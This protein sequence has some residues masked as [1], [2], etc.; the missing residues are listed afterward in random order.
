MPSNTEDSCPFNFL[1]KSYLSQAGNSGFK[2]LY[3]Q[4]AR[5]YY[6]AVKSMQHMETESCG[7]LS[8]KSRLQE[9]KVYSWASRLPAGRPRGLRKID[10]AQGSFF[11]FS[12]FASGSTSRLLIGR[13]MER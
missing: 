11:F 6:V 13:P 4:Y 5:A 3:V 9:H 8:I 1:E 7:T 2:D 12:F 10:Q